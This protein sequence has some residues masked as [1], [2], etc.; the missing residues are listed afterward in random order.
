MYD[1]HYIPC[2]KIKNIRTEKKIIEKNRINKLLFIIKN[3]SNENRFFLRTKI[4]MK[5][6]LRD[7]KKFAKKF[8][9][10]QFFGV[11]FPGD[12]FPGVTFWGTIFLRGNFADGHFPGRNFPGGIFP[13]AYF[14]EPVFAYLKLTSSITR[15]EHLL[16]QINPTVLVDVKKHF[17]SFVKS[18]KL[19]SNFTKQISCTFHFR[20]DNCTKLLKKLKER[21]KL[22]NLVIATVRI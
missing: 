8:Y 14:L 15:I 6:K 2:L 12:N 18:P 17:F 4:L 9:E 19:N 5:I 13:G 21:K 10:G 3:E 20:D 1:K 11:S 16:M 22:C 7:K